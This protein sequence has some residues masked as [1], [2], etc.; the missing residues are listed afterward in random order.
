M[1]GKRPIL[2]LLIS[3]VLGLAVGSLFRKARQAL[4]N[5]ISGLEASTGMGSNKQVRPTVQ[6]SFIQQ[7]EKKLANA[8]G[9]TRWLLWVEAVEKA[10]LEQFPEMV[11]L[12]KGAR[13]GEVF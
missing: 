9:V 3:V 10:P 4:H 1:K 12:A 2:V 5:P 7:L 6:L 8:K 13:C 11:E